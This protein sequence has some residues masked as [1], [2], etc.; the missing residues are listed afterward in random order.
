MAEMCRCRGRRVSLKRCPAGIR[1]ATA[2]DMKAV[3]EIVNHYIETTTV[4]FRTEPQTPEEWTADLLR[5]QDRYPWLVAD[6][7]SVVVGIAYATPWKA[8]SAYSWTAESTVYTSR[9]HQ[10]LGVGSALYTRLLECIEAQGFKSVVAVIGLPNDPSV[11]LHE[12]LGYIHRGT[13][14]AAG[15]KQDEWH[16]VGFWQRDF[17]VETPPRPVP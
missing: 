10:R 5:L 6:L 2:A 14:R 8:R 1:P 12:S 4:N 15:F 9:R 11:R 16:D 17:M 7:E 13:L 3:C